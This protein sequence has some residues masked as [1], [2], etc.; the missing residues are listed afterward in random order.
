[1][2][3]QILIITTFIYLGQKNTTGAIQ[4]LYLIQFDINKIYT[5]VS[6]INKNNFHK[7]CKFYEYLFMRTVYS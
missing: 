4:I 3:A 6:N 5:F 7:P 2:Y 1:M